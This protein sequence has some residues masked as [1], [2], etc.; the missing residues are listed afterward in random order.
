MKTTWKT[1]IICKIRPLSHVA[2]S[3]LVIFFLLFHRFFTFFLPVSCA[4][5]FYVKPPSD[6]P[7][8][9]GGGS[10]D[11]PTKVSKRARVQQ[12]PN[13]GVVFFENL[14]FSR[15]FMKI[16]AFFSEIFFRCQ[17]I[18]PHFSRKKDFFSKCKIARGVQKKALTEH[19]LASNRLKSYIFW[20]V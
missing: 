14:N 17:K 20:F 10:C 15:F 12:L 8:L 16:H 6:A 19:V 11:A 2:R 9:R 3:I 7:G 5:V 4:A 18:F 1:A 13:L